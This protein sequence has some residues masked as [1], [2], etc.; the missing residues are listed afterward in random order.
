MVS[1]FVGRY[2]GEGK[3]RKGGTG[4]EGGAGWAETGGA[5]RPASGEVMDITHNHMRMR[6]P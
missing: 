1:N 6:R 5:G 3:L 4:K 2:R